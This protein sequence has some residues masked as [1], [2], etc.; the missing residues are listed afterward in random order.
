MNKNML[1]EGFETILNIL[2]GQFVAFLSQIC[3]IRIRCAHIL[4]HRSKILC[5]NYIYGRSVAENKIRKALLDYIR[6]GS[7]L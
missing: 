3:Q 6:N 4:Y 5:L 2:M 7:H 1:K